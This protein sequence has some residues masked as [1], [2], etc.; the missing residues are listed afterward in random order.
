[1]GSGEVTIVGKFDRLTRVSI[2][3]VGI[4]RVANLIA[5]LVCVAGLIGSV[6]VADAIEARLV[7]KYGADLS[8]F[9]LNLLRGVVF[10]AL[11]TAYAVERL[12]QALRAMLNTVEGG[13]PFASVN[14][15]RL[16]TIGWMLLAIQVLDLTLGAVSV[17]AQSLSIDFV[18]WQPSLTGWIAVLVAFVLARVFT[19]GAAMRDDLEGTV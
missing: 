18:A 13:E 5:G 8:E 19:V 6:L 1:M 7:A 16:R 11:P 17:Y 4:V 15:A 9:T 12:C 10:L 14:A 2:S 3:V